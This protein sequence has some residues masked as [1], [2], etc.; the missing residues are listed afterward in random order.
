VLSLVRNPQGQRGPDAAPRDSVRYVT[1]QPILDLQ[2]KV[3]AYELL[4][5]EGPEEL[6]R[7]DREVAARTIVDNA[8]LFGLNKLTN[9]L[10]AFVPC[11]AEMLADSLV[12][13]LPAHMTVLEIRAGIDPPQALVDACRELHAAGYRFALDRFAWLPGI[14]HLVVLADYLKVSFA[15]TSPRERQALL[16]R[17]NCSR[18]TWV[19]SGVE[20]PEQFAEAKNAGF[21]FVQGFY[22]CRPSLLKSRKVPANRISQIEILQMLKDEELDLRRLTELVK[23]D[24][25]LTYRLL[26]LVN[27]PLCAMQQEVHSIQTA[28]LALG[29]E[30]F[31]RMAAVAITSEL[32]SG[33]PSEL[34]RMAFVRGR[35]CEQAARHCG[36]DGSEQYLLGLMSL[37]GVMLQTSMDELAPM[38]PFREGIR[39]ALK[40]EPADERVLLDWL[41]NYERGHWE[42]CEIIAEN[43]ELDREVLTDCFEEAVEWAEASLRFA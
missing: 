29:E 18:A 5:S 22:F 11:T 37:L 4:F 42:A 32:G 23:R 21:S 30:T 13:M 26:R 16:S 10:P 9:G 33:Q 14:D 7:R 36:L 31:R 43:R 1:R 17:F 35:F 15:D 41:E 2:N 39:R 34:L 24:T 40:G 25:S 3:R 12:E 8:V 19:A 28:L 20:T 38:L 6:L 27:S